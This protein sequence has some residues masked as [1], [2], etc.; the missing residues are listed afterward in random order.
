[1]PGNHGWP[2]SRGK[3]L[4]QMS[5]P[6]L[7]RVLVNPA[8]LERN[9]RLIAQRVGD[10]VR[11]MAMV[12]SD[13][14]GH[15]LVAAAEAFARAGC[16]T[17]GV[18]E[19]AEGVTLRES[20]C[21]GE[22]FILLGFDQAY[23][24][25]LFSHDL[26]PVIYNL[27]DLQ[28]LNSAAV[29]RKKTH[30]VYLKF[31]CGMKRLGFEPGEAQMLRTVTSGMEG[32]KLAGIISHYPCSEQ[33]SSGNSAEVYREFSGTFEVFAGV[34]GFVRSICNSGGTLYFPQS[35][36]EMIRAGISLYGY[37]PDGTN[38][39]VSETAA[40]LEPAMSFTTRVLQVKNVVRGSGIS[41]GHTYRAERDMQLAVL[42]VGYSNGYPRSLSNRAEVLIKGQR[43]PIR[44]RICMNLCMV[45]ITGIAGIQ[46]GE[47]VVLLGSQANDSIDADELGSRSDTISYEILCS[48]G[49]NNERMTIRSL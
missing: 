18:A 13:A 32:L 41:Y 5:I 19:I 16:S 49:N 14:Y 1:M 4:E 9:Y 10:Q 34:S 33:R 20:G 6:S 25:Y 11:V 12:K 21:R 2:G 27:R 22:I 44:G 39:R 29:A 46:P 28:L 8:A 42:P 3:D 30:A 40:R 7:S 15:G 35:H 17:F 48:I 24:D 36:N 45:E 47:E 23:V 26:T 37:Y 43:A 31:D 38:G